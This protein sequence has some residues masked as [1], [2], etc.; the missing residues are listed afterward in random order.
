MLKVIL[1]YKCRK[2]NTV[3]F[4]ILFLL[5]V[6]QKS[7]SQKRINEFNEQEM[8]YFKTFLKTTSHLKAY[9]TTP[10]AFHEPEIYSNEEAFYDTVITKFF[11]KEKMLKIFENDTSHLS[12]AGKVDWMRHILNEVDY[13]FDIIPSDSIFIRSYNSN[14]LPNTLE[15]YLIVNNKDI[16]IFLCHFDSSSALLV[17]LSIGA[18]PETKE[19]MSYLKRQKKYYEFPDPVRKN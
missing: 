15:V 1:Y 19:F 6:S 11:S 16:P 17:S 14:E 7:F 18:I 3:K 5:L 12:V 2:L 9:S 13:Y 4:F 10:L 8:Q